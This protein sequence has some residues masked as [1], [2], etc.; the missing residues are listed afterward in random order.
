M[1]AD[2][3]KNYHHLLAVGRQVVTE[4]GAEAS[5]R[6]IARKAGVGLATLYRHFPTREALLDALL[7]DSLDELTRRAIVL[8]TSTSPNEALVSWFSDGVAFVQRFSGAVNL[9]AAALSDKDSALHASCV[10]VRSAGAALLLRAQTEGAARQ[11][12]D[13]TDLFALM[14]ALGW[15]GDQPLF[16]PRAS[17][18]FEIVADAILKKRSDRDIAR[19]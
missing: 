10:A 18:L 17:H 9:M 14:G 6:D 1:R 4:H 5:L 13:G 3:K 15:L 11:D 16:A 7:R 8:E 12:I 2:A 19:C